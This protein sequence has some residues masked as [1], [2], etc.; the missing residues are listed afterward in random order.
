MH[1]S[2]INLL[3][4]LAFDRHRDRYPASP[5]VCSIVVSTSSCGGEILARID[6]QLATKGSEIETNDDYRSAVS[7]LMHQ[8]TCTRTDLAQTFVSLVPSLRN[9]ASNTFVASSE[10]YDT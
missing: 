6:L 3:N 1:P 7:V 5:D 10:S 2:F 4:R 8:T 9:Q